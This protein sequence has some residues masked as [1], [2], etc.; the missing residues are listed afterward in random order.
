M[1]LISGWPLAFPGSCQPLVEGCSA[2]PTMQIVNVVAILT[3]IEYHDCIVNL[4][5]VPHL[6]PAPCPGSRLTLLPL[7]PGPESAA[8][9]GMPGGVLLRERE[10][11]EE[12]LE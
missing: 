9:R 3:I 5:D 8:R 10:R 1:L 7:A 2:L 12:R 11:E 4:R 6:S